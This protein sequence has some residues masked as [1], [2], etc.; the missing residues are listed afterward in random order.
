M[1]LSRSNR[2]PQHLNKSGHHW[3]TLSRTRS[4]A[5]H[6]IT[7]R[8]EIIINRKDSKA[9]CSIETSINTKIKDSQVALNLRLDRA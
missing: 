4:Q 1:E 8:I 2:K 3:L 6:L 5:I 9:K 7:N